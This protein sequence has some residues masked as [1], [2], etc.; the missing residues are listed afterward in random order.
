MLFESY[1]LRHLS[2][3][4]PVVFRTRSTK[5]V[6]SGFSSLALSMASACV[7]KTALA[8]SAFDFLTA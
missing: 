8:R 6:V 2:G 5:G 7:G 4:P 3:L 1:G